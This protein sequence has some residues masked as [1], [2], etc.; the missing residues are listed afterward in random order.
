MRLKLRAYFSVALM[1]TGAGA[2]VAQS[3]GNTATAGGTVV[4]GHKH[5]VISTIPNG[6]PA[7]P[8]AG[9]ET[10]VG[11][12]LPLTPELAMHPQGTIGSG[13]PV[14]G[15]GGTAAGSTAATP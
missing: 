3:T 2:A 13:T 14:A 9:S 8:V 15:P 11:V 6:A 7:H 10:P 5:S 4:T 1:V 12:N